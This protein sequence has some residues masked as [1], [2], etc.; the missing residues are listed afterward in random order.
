MSDLE[1]R[2]YA[3]AALDHLMW[4][5]QPSQSPRFEAKHRLAAALRERDGFV[6]E[7]S[8][9]PL[10]TLQAS[11]TREALLEA[12]SG[13]TRP[14]VV[15]GFARETA[16]VRGWT[17]ARLEAVLGDVD[18]QVYVQDAD[19][20]LRSWDVGTKLE[21]V[22][23]R[24]YL[25]RRRTEPLYLNNST[26]LFL[27]RPELLDDLDLGALRDRFHTP[28]STWDELV[29]A[30]LFLGAK[31]VFS[32][33]HCAYGGNFFLNVTG[34]KRWIFVDPIYGPHL[35]A[36]PGR[37]FQFLKSAYGGTRCA[38]EGGGTDVLSV[39]PRFEVVLEPGDLLYNPPWWWHEVDNLD[40]LTLGV[41]LR[42]VPPPTQGMPTWSNHKVWSLLS[43][44]P[45]AQAGITAHW[46]ASKVW[47]S[48][49]STRALYGERQVAML[50]R[51]LGTR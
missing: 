35:H 26:E 5:G 21:R 14:V 16:A 12:S 45:A 19:S 39:L 23:F 37:P 44:W 47:P 13:L 46:A 1:A 27:A 2:F 8:A 33:V 36:L 48:L 7:R 42:H 9:K 18:C 24:E 38:E 30:N 6:V 11:A 17:E 15:R 3:L 4:K 20:R 51:G 49:P 31:H 34:R 43:S 41:A 50:R 29:T 28:G 10:P 32:A 40:D 25:R 22:T